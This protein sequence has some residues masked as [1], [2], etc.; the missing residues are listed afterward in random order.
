MQ[1]IL[2]EP[3]PNALT[4]ITTAARAYYRQ[5]VP[6]QLTATDF[7]DWLALLPAATRADLERQGFAV[8]GHQLAFLRH[9]LELRGYSMR[10][11][12]MEQLS[13]AAY[14]L[15]EK[16]YEFNG[17]LPDSVCFN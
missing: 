5:S 14:E 15:W 8:G 17:D 4:E 6:L 10:Q 2:T 1:S 7:F 3:T 16:H 12:M 11:H 9:C 13:V